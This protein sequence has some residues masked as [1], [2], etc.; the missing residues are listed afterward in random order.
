MRK[1]INSMK[2]TT[3]NGNYCGG[4]MIMSG[5]QVNIAD[6]NAV[7]NACQV[8][9][10]FKGVTFNGN[11]CGGDMVV[12]GNR[13]NVS[14][15]GSFEDAELKEFNYDDA[16]VINEDRV[17]EV[18]EIVIKTDSE[19]VG[20][21]TSHKDCVSYDVSVRGHSLSTEKAKVSIT[22]ENGRLS[23]D[24]DDVGHSTNSDINV[25]ITIP[26]ATMLD[27]IDVKTETGYIK[28]GVDGIVAGKAKFK[29]LAGCIS[30]E[31]TMPSNRIKM[32]SNAGVVC[33][34]G[35]ISQDTEIIAKT[36]A[37][38]INIGLRNVS[39]INPDIRVSVGHQNYAPCLG[40]RCKLDLVAST[41][42][43][44]INIY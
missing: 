28:C 36:E 9:N 17:A 7:V 30:L 24:V 15:D 3:F 23:I 5:Q 8:N 41:T 12:G 38:A 34:T 6:G 40:G 43:G 14:S 26:P 13:I 27:K 18:R 22:F 1:I 42:C 20:I 2:G 33:A 29:T 11:F 10:S 16:F 21:K 4:D 32:K 35:G 39:Q 44:S 31:K 19:N 37:G 25:I